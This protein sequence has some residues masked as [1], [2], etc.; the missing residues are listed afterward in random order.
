MGNDV[1]SFL[2]RI[3]SVFYAV[4]DVKIGSRVLYQVPEGLVASSRQERAG[5]SSSFSPPLGHG[6]SSLSSISESLS[7][8]SGESGTAPASPSTTDGGQTSRL[9]RSGT[10]KRN[11]ST[12]AQRT[13]FYFD[14]ISK[15]VIPAT[16]LCGRLVKCTTRNH[17]IIGY[18][19]ELRNDEKYD[20]GRFQYNLCFVFDKSADLSCYEPVVRKV[21]RVLTACEVSWPVRAVTTPWL[22]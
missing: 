11:T 1:D 14:D 15:Y 4:L 10:Q 5:S 20:R 16:Q 19:V 3:E 13:L 6:L 21:G 9:L 2:P 12:S 8:P 17:R 7:P 22:V 18:P